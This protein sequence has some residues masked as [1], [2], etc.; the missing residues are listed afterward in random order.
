MSAAKRAGSASLLGT[1]RKVAPGMVSAYAGD[2]VR[3]EGVVVVTD[4]QSGDVDRPPTLD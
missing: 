3:M 4:D 1:V 2:L